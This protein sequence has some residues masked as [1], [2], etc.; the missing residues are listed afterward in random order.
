M[1]NKIKTVYATLVAFLEANVD[2]RV[3]DILDEA[4]EMCSAKQGG[5]G[6]ARSFHKIDDKVV[7]ARCGYFGTWYMVDEVEFGAKAS[8]ASGLNTMC[9]AGTSA[10][11]KQNSEYKK[12]R[13]QLLDAVATGEVA[14][15]D[16]Q[17]K[18]AEIEAAKD[19]REDAPAGGYATL[20]ALLADRGLA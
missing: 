12:A 11:T 19:L 5:G 4:K 6:G 17:A 15:D 14:I 10:W 16:M 18:L 8:S 3:R 20:E 13:E 9:K 1:S 7:A 2:K